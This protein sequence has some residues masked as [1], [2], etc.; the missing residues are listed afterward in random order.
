LPISLKLCTM[1]LESQAACGPISGIA[2]VEA[3]SMQ[4]I[5]VKLR[6][7]DKHAAALNRQ[8]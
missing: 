8:A 3:Q 2:S 4:Q 6:V 7:R 1:F 5:T